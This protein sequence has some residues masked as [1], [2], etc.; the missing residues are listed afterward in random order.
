MPTPTVLIYGLDKDAPYQ[1]RGNLALHTIGTW[2]KNLVD[3]EGFGKRNDFGSIQPDS[4]YAPS[5]YNY[6]YDY[7][8]VNYGLWAKTLHLNRATYAE[9]ILNDD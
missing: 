6:K 8:P 4:A 5:Q 7:S 1:Y 3:D 2:I 9:K